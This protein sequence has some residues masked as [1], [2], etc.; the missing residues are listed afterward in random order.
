[1]NIISA[2]T[3][4]L[5]ESSAAEFFEYKD[6]C[7][8]CVKEM[9][10]Q[11]PN[12][13]QKYFLNGYQSPR[14]KLQHQEKMF[15]LFDY[16]IATAEKATMDLSFV[17]SRCFIADAWVNIANSKSA[18]LFNTIQRDTFTGL[19]FLKAPTNSGKLFISNP[20]MNLSW[21]GGLLVE[22]KNQY[23]SEKMHIQ[24]KE[25]QLFV[26]PSYLSYGIEPNA[27][28]EETICVVMSI[29]AIPEEA[30]NEQQQNS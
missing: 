14:K 15:P 4:P 21:Q 16:T 9:Q 8:S 25:G 13:D 29:I 7:I 27:T 6:N 22:H 24:P 26:F 18:V 1:M 2:F 11:Y 30:W 10:T 20:A 28:D 17:P 19:I 3:T 5:W 23:N 12:P